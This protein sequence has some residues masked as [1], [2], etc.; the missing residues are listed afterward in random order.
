MRR[1]ADKNALRKGGFG[2]WEDSRPTGR[3][4]KT[5]VFRLYNAST[6][7][8]FPD[9]RGKTANSVDVDVPSRPENTPKGTMEL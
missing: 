1:S 6:S 4:R 3:G 2:K 7:T 9:S 8:Q 5:R